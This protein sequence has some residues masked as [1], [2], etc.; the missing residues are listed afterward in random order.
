MSKVV[1]AHVQCPCCLTNIIFKTIK[2][3]PFQPVCKWVTCSDDEILKGCGSKYF[4]E[5]KW[6]YGKV[7]IDSIEEQISK[8]GI[9]IKKIRDENEKLSAKTPSTKGE[10][11]NAKRI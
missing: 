3:L 2:P 4:L 9:E 11:A 6:H 5:I 7:L 10:E 8:K 1:H